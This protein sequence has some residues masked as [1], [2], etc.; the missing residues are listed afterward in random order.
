MEQE[1]KF[2]GWKKDTKNWKKKNGQKRRGHSSTRE[3][4]RKPQRSKEPG[5]KRKEDGKH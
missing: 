5:G 1:E 2:A 3:E 4:F